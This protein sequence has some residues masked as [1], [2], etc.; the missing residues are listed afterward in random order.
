MFQLQAC[1]THKLYFLQFY[2][3]NAGAEPVFFGSPDLK[4]PHFGTYFVKDGKVVGAFVEGA[5]GDENN[6]MKKVAVEQPKAP[7]DLAK[8]GFSFATSL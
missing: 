4:S 8:Q 3:D 7:S 5:S 1:E 6:A 2:G